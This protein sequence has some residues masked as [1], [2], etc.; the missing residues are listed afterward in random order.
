MAAPA[1]P[2]AHRRSRRASSRLCRT[3][4]WITNGGSISNQRYSP[5][6]QIN[7]GN[8]AGLKGLWHVHL[9]SGIAGKYSGEAQPI[10]YK[11]VIYVVTG[12][13]D[14][15]AIDAKTRQDEVVVPRE[16]EPE[17]QHDLLRLDEPRR[18][19]RRRE[20]LP[21]PARR[22]A[23]R[24][25][26]GERPGRVDDA[27]RPLPAGLHDHERAAL[28]QRPRLHRALR[29]RVRDP[30]PPDGVR[31]QDGQGSTGA[32]T[33]SPARARSGHE[34]W[35]SDN[36]SW[37]HGG[38]PVWQTP[39]VDPKLGLLYFS[40]GNAAPDLNGAARAG[41]NLFSSS[42]LA[43]DAKT[44]KYRWHFQEVH[45]DIWDY[46]APSPVVL[47]DV[48][49]GGQQRQAIAQA[50]K[51]GFVYILDRETGKPLI[52]IDEQPG[53]AERRPR[54]PRQL[55]PSRAATPP[56]AQSV[57]PSRPSARSRQTLPKGTQLDERRSH[58]HARTPRAARSSRRRARSAAPTGSR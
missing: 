18:R 20:G 16:P 3:T 42:I 15:F 30:R 57:A 27:G 53:A 35:P 31:R 13:D 46:D 22:Q 9:G 50:G 44:G 6:T 1:V 21:R 24:A 54:R 8:V 39:A 33:R 2:A 32:S 5:L 7:S 26:P 58:L 45:H 38:A 29:R 49:V 51:T 55:S 47:F 37:K 43:L 19:A 36:D 10:V 11:N 41:D 12:A 17:D 56:I 28:L 48:S 34:T 4:N 25:R 14:V 40:T 23:R 52:G